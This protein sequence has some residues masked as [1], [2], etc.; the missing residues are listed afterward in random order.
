MGERTSRTWFSHC[1]FCIA[2]HRGSD[3]WRTLKNMK[4]MVPHGLSQVRQS[5]L[6]ARWGE[7]T[8]LLVR[9]KS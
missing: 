9:A 4:R 7:I 1:L 5:T 6:A 3:K 2:Y 8:G